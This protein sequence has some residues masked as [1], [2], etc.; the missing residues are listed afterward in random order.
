MTHYKNITD[1]LLVLCICWLDINA[2]ATFSPVQL[3]AQ[4][5]LLSEEYAP[6]HAKLVTVSC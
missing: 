3:I 5:Q 2:W 4:Q 1:L 6:W